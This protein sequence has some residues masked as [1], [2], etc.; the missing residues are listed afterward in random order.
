MQVGTGPKQIEFR[1]CAHVLP[2]SSKFFAKASEEAP[3]GNLGRKVSLHAHQPETFRLYY[4]WLLKDIIYSKQPPEG[5]RKTAREAQVSSL[6]T[7]LRDL[8]DALILGHAIE[9]TNFCDVVTDALVECT[10]EL[11]LFPAV[12]ASFLYERLPSTS[13]AGQLVVD[14]TAYVSTDRQ[15]QSLTIASTEVKVHQD[16]ILKFL[17]AISAIHRAVVPASSPFENWTSTCKYHVHGDKTSCYRTKAEGY[18]SCH[19]MGL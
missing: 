14:L 17:K 19:N 8:G 16:F 15:I 12:F 4:Q 5:G 9:D 7:E 1:V 3:Q 13:P 18:V 11:R 2:K 10:E 6:S